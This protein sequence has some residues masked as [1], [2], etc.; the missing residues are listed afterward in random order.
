[1]FFVALLHVCTLLDLTFNEIHPFSYVALLANK[2][3]MNFSSTMKQDDQDRFIEALEKEVTD[4]RRGPAP[5]NSG[6]H[7]PVTLFKLIQFD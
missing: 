3:T 2:D 5:S 1:M 4:H 7:G 6:L